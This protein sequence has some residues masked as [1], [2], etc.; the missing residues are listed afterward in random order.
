M[1]TE[2]GRGLA[3]EIYALRDI[4]PGEEIFMDYGLA[5]E[6]AWEQHV[7]QWKA[8]AARTGRWISAA[9][10]NSNG[11]EPVIQELITNDLR[12]LLEP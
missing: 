11:T 10:A 7:M 12:N 5:Y 9:D 8:P 2:L 6:K 3:F 1:S 4:S